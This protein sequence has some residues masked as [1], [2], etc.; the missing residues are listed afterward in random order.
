MK[1]AH[2]IIFCSI[3]LHLSYAFAEDALDVV[4]AKTP[5]MLGEQYCCGS[6]VQTINSLRHAG[7][8]EAISKLRAY[9]EGG[10][11]YSS[12]RSEQV[13]ILCRL[14]FVN[15][16]GWKTPRLGHADPDVDFAI[17]DKLPY[18]PIVL[19]DGV[20]FFVI[21]GYQSGGYSGDTAEKC[22][23]LCAQ[24]QM[25]TNDMSISNCTSA[26]RHL[27]ESN[28]FGE[29]YKDKDNVKEMSEMIIDQ[30]ECAKK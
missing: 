1:Y 3:S 6:M 27:V 18:F 9:C 20:P 28:E 17:T 11:A 24:Y 10:N 5:M 14:L 25:L 13:L 23:E 8:K 7:P 29:I 26:A 4:L 12:G 19:S 2:I 30:A 15:P 16:N 21:K 22:L